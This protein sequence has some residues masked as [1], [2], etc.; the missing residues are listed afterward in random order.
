MKSEGFLGIFTGH[1]A[2]F[3]NISKGEVKIERKVS[4][5]EPKFIKSREESVGIDETPVLSRHKVRAEVRIN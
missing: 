2:R 5:F 1:V 3:V 4:F